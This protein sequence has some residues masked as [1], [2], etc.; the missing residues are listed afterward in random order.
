[1]RNSIFWAGVILCSVL[2]SARS[3]TPTTGEIIYRRGILPSGKPVAGDR[4][5]GGSASGATAA[6]INCHRRSGL[7]TVEGRIVIPPIT[8]RYLYEA[9]PGSAAE[10]STAEGGTAPHR[11][12]PYTDATL[13]RAI[14]E[15]IAPDGRS[16]NYLMPRYPL[17]DDAMASLITYI[18]GLSNGQE[19]GVVGDT[20]HFATIITPDADPVKRKAMLE[21]MEHFFAAKNLFSRG[22]APPLQASRRLAFRVLRKWQL[23]VWDLSG[24]P[25]TWEEQLRKK[26]RAEP[27]FAVISGLGGKDWAPIHRFCEQESIPCLFPNVDLPVVAEEDFYDVYFSKGVL[28]EAQLMARQIQASAKTAD[29]RRVVQVYRDEDVG[30]AA[31]GAL[32]KQIAAS[33]LATVDRSLSTGA[34][35]N[36]I[37]AAIRTAASNDALVLWLR[38][39][40]LRELPS[41]APNNPAVFMS[42][43]MGE[44]EQAPLNNSWRGAVQ[45]TYPYELPAL[46]AARL[47]YVLAWFKIQKIPVACERTQVDTYVACGILA[48]NLDHMLDNFVRDY[49]VENVEVMLSPRVVNGYYTRLGLGPGQRFAS[50][51][52]YVV[53]FSASDEKKLIPGGDWIVP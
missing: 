19:P 12:I 43:V 16:F 18:K 38:P 49:L 23:H 48:E 25:E 10:F 37:G 45:M 41:E 28:L 39:D 21:V 1:M 22:P 9:A 2:T 52:G 46:R 14:R 7:G 44:L 47:N 24:E 32:R 33:G 13:A 36:E 35:A 15:G 53:R 31:A 4:E 8:A 26:F 27:V 51:G 34:A 5:S 6:C 50:K 11:L 42:G 30:K 20:L 17:G 3:N 40:D 29:L